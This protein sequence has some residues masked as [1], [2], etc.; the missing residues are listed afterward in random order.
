[1]IFLM[2]NL[3][4]TLS[5]KLIQL[6]PLK[7]DEFEAL[8]EAASDPL[9][10]AQHPSPLRYQREVFQK[11]FDE[12]IA[13]MGALAVV[14]CETGRVIGS[15]RYYA[16]N[17]ERSEVVIGY[18]FLVRKF[19]GGKYNRELKTLMLGHIFQFVDDVL[20]HV[21]SKNTRSQLAM[22]RVGGEL[23]ES[24]GDPW[25]YRIKKNASGVHKLG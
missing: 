3:Q 19:W 22:E 15:S 25:I 14:D 2:I 6:R 11:F 12:A 5:G 20:F 7:S 18:T 23:I 21:G 4:P 24:S 1:M 9:I 8:F 16:Y 10:W 17:P 13:C